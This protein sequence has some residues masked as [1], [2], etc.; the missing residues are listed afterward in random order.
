MEK[1]SSIARDV[2]PQN[3]PVDIFIRL[4]VLAAVLA[5]CFQILRP[6][7]SMIIWGIIIAVATY[8]VYEKLNTKLGDRRKLAGAVI[9][10]C[11]LLIIILPGVYL[12]VSSGNSVYDL[13][14]KLESGELKLPPPPEEVG[15]W[16]V[17]GESVKNVWQK[18]S[19]NLE[20]TLVKL[21]PQ[22]VALGKWL[23]KTAINIAKDLLIFAVS[24]IIAGILLISAPKG[25][26]MTKSLFRRLVGDRGDEFIDITV[27][28][29]RSV[30]KG[31]LGVALIQALLAGLGFAVAGVPHAGLWA[32]ICLFLAMIQISIGLVVVPIIIYAF[33]EMSTLTAVILT[34]W[35]VLVTIADGPLKAVL[36]GKGAPVPMTV[37]F[38]GAI[39]GFI[40]FGFLGLFIGAVILSVGYKLFE[41]WLK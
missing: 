1:T 10:L 35:L 39:G 41:L 23:L 7:I 9:T 40:A 15:N 25:V 5:G 36:L 28:T 2:L 19:A 14:V 3:R 29:V 31:I 24:I 22:L 17:I 33:S 34:V 18:A 13:S 27:K 38:L 32:F 8:P 37:I 16:P 21:K 26:E 12:A 6:F 11:A 30:V 4:G 20:P